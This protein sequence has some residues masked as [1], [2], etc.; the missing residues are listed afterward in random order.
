MPPQSLQRCSCLAQISVMIGAGHKAPCFSFVTGRPTHNL[1]AGEVQI[2]LHSGWGSMHHVT[3]ASQQNLVDTLTLLIEGCSLEL[4]SS[5]ARR[6]SC[7]THSYAAPAQQQQ[8]GPDISQLSSEL[9]SQWDHDKNAYLGKIVVRPHSHR[10]VHWVCRKCPDGHPHIWEARVTDRTRGTGCSLCSGQKVCPHNSLPSTA[11][12]VAMDWDTAKNP[13]SSHDHTSR[14]GYQAH[15][16]CNKCGHGWLARIAD[17]T[18]YGNG[19]PHCASIRQR[20]RLPTVTASSSSMKH[21]WHS[22]RNAEQGLDPDIITVGSGQT[23]NFVCDM[24]PEMQPH[25]WT[26]KVKDVFRGGACPY[27]S[28]HCVCQ[29]NSLQTLRPDLAAEWCYALNKGNPNDYTAQSHEVVWWQNDKRGRWKARIDT[30]FKTCNSQVC[31]MLHFGFHGATYTYR[32]S[33]QFS[34]Q[35]TVN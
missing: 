11:P 3:N 28:G 21:Y 6:Y 33:K 2:Y 4:R 15:W 19:C 13:G 27:C 1:H 32:P 34:S 10:K 7:S 31:T 18:K 30:R 9:Q 35:T 14:S 23:A 26:A 5:T 8:S 22:Q 20:R 12:Q 17:R 16:L 29:C 24:C 25:M